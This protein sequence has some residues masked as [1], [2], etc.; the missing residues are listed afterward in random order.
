MIV[1]API[2]TTSLRKM[3]SLLSVDERRKTLFLFVLMLV[4][5]YGII[6]ELSK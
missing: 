1:Q 2:K 5:I 4:V 6:G 3:W